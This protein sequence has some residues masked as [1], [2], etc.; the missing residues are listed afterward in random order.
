MK[1]KYVVG[2]T[3]Y[4]NENYLNI[5][6]ENGLFLISKLYKN[7]T[8]FEVAEKKEK[9]GGKAKIGRPPLYGNQLCLAS[10]DKKYLKHS[11]KDDKETCIE[12]YRN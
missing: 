6:S 7:A 3:A 11:E 9:K 10:L 8:L 5:V 4:G 2:D 1:V 12:T